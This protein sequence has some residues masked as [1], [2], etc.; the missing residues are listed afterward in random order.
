MIDLHSHILPEMDDGS[1]STE[2]SLALLRMQARQGVETVI[3][4]PHFYPNSESVEAFLARRE[5]AFFRLR[6]VFLDEMPEI[7]L[8]AEVQYY[9]GISRMERLFDL[10]IEKSRLL[11]LE[12]PMMRWNESIVRELLELSSRSCLKV[13]LAHVERYLPMQEEIVIERLCAN[14]ILF[15]VN[16]SCF[17]SFRTRRKAFSLMKKGRVHFVGSDCHGIAFRPPK[18]GKAFAVIEKRFGKAYVSQ[19]NEYGVS[20]LEHK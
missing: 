18:I 2:E 20:M 17:L 13:V 3:A 14:G 6:E 12:M 11:L 4:T 5:K 16:A 8:G 1:Q 7:R 15:Q 9:Q 19:M 10:R